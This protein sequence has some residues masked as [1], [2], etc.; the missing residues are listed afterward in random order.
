VRA[1]FRAL[2]EAE[3]DRYL[4]LDARLPVDELAAQIRRRVAGLLS[5][6]PLQTRPGTSRGSTASGRGRTQ[7]G[8]AP[9]HPHAQTGPT[10]Q[11]HP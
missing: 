2:A 9:S 5:G 11:L 6:L 7:D 3:A 1:T 8:A 4:V 10:P